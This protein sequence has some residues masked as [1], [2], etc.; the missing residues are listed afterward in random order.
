[1]PDIFHLTI[2]VNSTVPLQVQPGWDYHEGRMQGR[3]VHREQ[4]GAAQAVIL[5][6]QA[7]FNVPL[8]WVTSADAATIRAA[9]RDNLEVIWTVN[10]SS[11]P[12]SWRCSIANVDDPLPHREPQNFNHFGGMLFLK[13]S[14]GAGEGDMGP[15]ILDNATWGLLDQ[16][17]NGLL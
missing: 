5:H 13:E 11:S 8:T 7:Y 16:S 9:W 14:T 4:V 17:Y 6:P 15:F 2:A 3:M 12:R 1:M 10:A